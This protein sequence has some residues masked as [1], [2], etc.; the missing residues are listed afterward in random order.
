MIEVSGGGE[1]RE[2]EVGAQRAA[3]RDAAGAAAARHASRFPDTL[4]PLAV[5]QERSIQLVN[6]VLRRRPHARD[7]RARKDPEL[8]APGPD[9]LYDVGVVGVVARMLKV[10]DGTLRILVQGGQRVRIERWT[11]RD[12]VPRRARSPS[13]PT[14]SSETPELT[15]LMRN[16]QQTFSRIIEEVPY[17]PEELQMRSPTS[18]TRAR[19]RT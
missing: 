11:R 19:S 4:T 2:V 8:E 7:G 5:G 3:A 18:T 16:V 12:A 13:C 1:G 17:L 9:E 14:S 15:A 10:P 6:D